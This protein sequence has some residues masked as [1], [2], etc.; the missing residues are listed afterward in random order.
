M[1][2]MLFKFREQNYHIPKHFSPQRRKGAAF[3]LG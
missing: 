3:L 2:A 1:F